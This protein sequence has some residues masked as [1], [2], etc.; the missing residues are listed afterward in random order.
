[1]ATANAFAFDSARGCDLSYLWN[2]FKSSI[3]MPDNE[4]KLRRQVGFFNQELD[5][6]LDSYVVTKMN[7]LNKEF[8]I[9]LNSKKLEDSEFL[10]FYTK[11]IKN[12]LVKNQ[13]F[14]HIYFYGRNFSDILDESIEKK[15]LNSYTFDNSGM[16]GGV[17][18]VKVPTSR[19]LIFNYIDRYMMNI[20]GLKYFDGNVDYFNGKKIVEN[21]G[22]R[23]IDQFLIEFYYKREWDLINNKKNSEDIFKKLVL[24]SKWC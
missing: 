9:V 20:V 22:F 19:S 1:M 3:L 13:E 7:F 5:S 21:Y 12:F 2:V 6:A 11:D 23:P 4:L 14:L 16:N 15:Y 8:S 18:L 24:N 17:L 10:I